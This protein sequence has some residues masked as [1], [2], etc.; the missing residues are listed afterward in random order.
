MVDK[1]DI[2]VTYLSEGTFK[3]NEL[4]VA[5]PYRILI[6][7]KDPRVYQ[8]KCYVEFKDDFS[9]GTL[10]FDGVKFNFTPGQW[11]RNRYMDVQV[12]FPTELTLS[13]LKG[14]FNNSPKLYFR[15]TENEVMAGLIQSRLDIKPL[16]AQ[17]K[18]LQLK[19]RDVN[20]QKATDVV[21]AIASEF[22]YY[23]VD[24][25][26]E[27]SRNILTFV[28]AQLEIVYSELK[29]TENDLQNFQFSH[30][31][32]DKDFLK[33]LRVGQ[34]SG[35]EDQLTQIQLNERMLDDVIKGIAQNSSADNYKLLSLISGTE[36]ENSIKEITSQLQKLLTEK[37][38]LLYSYKPDRKSTR[39]NSSH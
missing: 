24:R 17:A 16:N 15:V 13:Q 14:F 9:K 36:S 19:Y 2:G 26:S 39:L 31:L 5:N 29:K 34:F 1:L 32:S 21:N 23:D 27:S 6:R 7:V 8:H 25:K 22:L 12:Y 35:I 30:K 28:N 3:S 33:S 18:T 11:M 37:E 4:Y 10:S 38:T 20:S